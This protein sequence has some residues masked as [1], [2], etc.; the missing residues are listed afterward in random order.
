MKETLAFSFQRRTP[1]I[2]DGVLSSRVFSRVFHS[3]RSVNPRAAL[4][5][6]LIYFQFKPEGRTFSHFTLYSVACIVQF[7]NIFLR[8]KV[9]VRFP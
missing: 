9:R 2:T 5:N 7:Q 4:L 3:A 6:N 8:S 1:S